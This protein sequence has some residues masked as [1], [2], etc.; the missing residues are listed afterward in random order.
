MAEDRPDEALTSIDLT[1]FDL[2]A[3]LRKDSLNAIES[4]SP[5]DWQQNYNQIVRYVINTHAS[6]EDYARLATQL[7]QVVTDEDV[8]NAAERIEKEHLFKH[9]GHKIR[10]ADRE[11]APGWDAWVAGV[12][13]PVVLPLSGLLGRTAPPPPLPEVVPVVSAASEIHGMPP[14]GDSEPWL[15][16]APDPELLR[17]IV[18]QLSPEALEGL[19]PDQRFEVT[20]HVFRELSQLAAGPEPESADTL[21]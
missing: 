6:P 1:K 19:S 15:M 11:H 5:R 12:I 10:T 17:S 18:G 8:Q 4:D 13:I 20:Q 9:I 3:L 2:L 14:S 16:Y 7:H 21:N